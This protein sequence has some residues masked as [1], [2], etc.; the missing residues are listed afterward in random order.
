MTK[1]KLNTEYFDPPPATE[2]TDQAPDITEPG[3]TDEQPPIHNP[4]ETSPQQY[5]ALESDTLEELVRIVESALTATPT[6]QEIA[7]AERLASNL[8][9]CVTATNTHVPL[10]EAT[11]YS[12]TDLPNYRTSEGAHPWPGNYEETTTT[13]IRNNESETKSD[14]YTSAEMKSLTSSPKSTQPSAEQLRN[15]QP[16]IPNPLGVSI[17]RR[18]QL[19]HSAGDAAFRR[20]ELAKCKADPVYWVN[21]YVWTYDPRELCA[22]R[23]F[24]LFLRQEEFLNWLAERDRLQQSGLA[25]K[26]RDVGFTW[27]CAVYALHRWLYYKGDSTGFG[28]RKLDLVDHKDNPDCIFE[29]IRFVLRRLPVWMRPRGF[30]P[31]QHDKLLTLLNPVNGSTITGEG[32][33]EIGRGGRKSRYFVDEA[34]YLQNPKTTDAALS[35]T[36]RVRIDVSTPNGTGNPFHSKRFNGS[37]PVFTFH[38][39]DDPRKDDEWYEREKLRI[40]DPVIIA[41]ELDIDYTASI[42]NVCIPAEW[43]RS[44][45]N[46]ELKVSGTP[47]AGWDIADEGRC[48][49]VLITRHG[50]VVTGVFDWDKMDLVQSAHRAAA[51]CNEKGAT[52]LNYDSVGIGAGVRGIFNAAQN[53]GGP[54]SR[55]STIAVNVGDQPTTSIWPD[56]KTSRERFRNLRAELWWKLRARFEKTHA[57]VQNLKLTQDSTDVNDS[58][59]IEIDERSPEQIEH[60]E[61][62]DRYIRDNTYRWVKT[63]GGEFPVYDWMEDER[64]RRN[65]IPNLK[66]LNNSTDIKEMTDLISIPDNPALIA[67]LSMPVFFYTETGK[68]QLE[69]KQDMRKRGISS[70]DYADALVLAFSYTPV[71]C[72]EYRRSDDDLYTKWRHISW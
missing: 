60:D 9:S 61:R 19:L 18:L 72:P 30:D 66:D 25:E 48:K 11:T 24:D 29:K 68:V 14:P 65:G 12:F 10:S 42:E 55:L 53:A 27:L 56:G 8:R 3:A 41:Q 43:V 44:A 59:E 32:G 16:P 62:L 7:R 34:A 37:V 5:D 22:T 63:L 26:S 33:S 1:H 64:N 57:Y 49:N 20:R 31:R 45:I 46:L 54:S 52:S 51:F 40:A 47:N 58:P 15:P 35:Q 38:W 21:N 36:T 39:R 4:A 69:S 71:L 50:P 28:S 23:P 17:L 67:Q 2:D 6:K 13:T 70:P